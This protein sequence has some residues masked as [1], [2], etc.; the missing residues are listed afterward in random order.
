MI[1]KVA[2]EVL[3][4][5]TTR[6]FWTLAAVTFGLILL[7]V[8][9]SLII[10]DELETNEDAVR[11][12][13]STGG[14]AGVFMLI[15]GAVVGAGEYRHGTIA[16]TLLVTPNRL[17]AVTAQTLAC[18]LGGFLVGLAA[19][20][21]VFALSVPVLSGRDAPMP[22]TGTVLRIVLGTASSQGSRQRSA[23]RSGR[24]CGTRWRPSC[25]CCSSSSWWTRSS[26]GWPGTTRATRSPA[27][28]PR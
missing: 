26:R 9:L 17:H 15:L 11:S 20:A 19:V 2:A 18:T 25:P 22:E 3:K 1:G 16:S 24:R 8:V 27:S 13:L 4:L 21:I 12:L 28:A 7:I 14:L 6:T 5:R 10:D 23:W